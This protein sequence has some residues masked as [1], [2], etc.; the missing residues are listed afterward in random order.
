MLNRE[1]VSVGLTRLNKV[2]RSTVLAEWWFQRESLCSCFMNEQNYKLVV[3][4]FN[5][6]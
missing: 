3:T 5:F 2:V 1:V 4:K 6:T